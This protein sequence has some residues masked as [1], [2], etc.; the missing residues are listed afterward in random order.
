MA[1][2]KKF[3]HKGICLP[4]VFIAITLTCIGLV[5]VLSASYNSTIL[6]SDDA[7]ILDDVNFQA[8]VAVIGILVMFGISHIDYHYFA[9]PKVLI[10]GFAVC[11]VMLL[12]VFAFAPTYD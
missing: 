7:S 4:L 2:N 11:I 12:A 10:S 5:M 1:K 8:I 6:S 3:V 9:K